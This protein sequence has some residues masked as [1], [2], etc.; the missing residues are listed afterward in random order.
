MYTGDL[1]TRDETPSKAGA[2]AHSCEM[3]RGSPAVSAGLWGC[4][5]LT[6]DEAGWGTS[7]GPVPTPLS[8]PAGSLE[9]TEHTYVYKVQGTGVTPP[10]TP[11]GPRIKQ[12][13]PGTSQLH[14]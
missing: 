11:S 12:R 3:A 8:L 13:L 10:Q 5:T 7:Q 4:R 6:G 2:H 1:G 9:S 14:V